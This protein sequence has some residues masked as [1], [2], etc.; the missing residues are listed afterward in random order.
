MAIQQFKWVNVYVGLLQNKYVFSK[1]VLSTVFFAENVVP[2][3]T[4]HTDR[5]SKDMIERQSV[6]HQNLLEGKKSNL[7]KNRIYT[8]VC[9]CV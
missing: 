1:M 4:L 2:L 9:V 6:N 3:L 8:D 7:L 5:V